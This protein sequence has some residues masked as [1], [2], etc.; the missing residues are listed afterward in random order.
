MEERGK[1]ARST[2][3]PKSRK[4]N[5]STNGLEVIDR[6]DDRACKIGW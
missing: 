2:Y 4:E 1:K 5:N 3:M 6:P